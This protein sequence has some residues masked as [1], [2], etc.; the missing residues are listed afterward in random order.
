MRYRGPEAILEVLEPFQEVLED[1]L[2]YSKGR[3]SVTVLSVLLMFHALSK[4]IECIPEVSCGLRGASSLTGSF[5]STRT[6]HGR[7]RRA[8][9]CLKGTQRVPG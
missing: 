1:F 4:G 2:Q 5:R 9:N 3:R 6:S 8:L 7:F